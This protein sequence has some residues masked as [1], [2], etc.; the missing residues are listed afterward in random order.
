MKKMIVALLFTFWLPALQVGAEEVSAKP[1]ASRESKLMKLL[2]GWNVELGGGRAFHPGTAETGQMEGWSNSS[3]FT[4]R[5]GYTPKLTKGY[6]EVQ[7]EYADFMGYDSATR[8]HN[9]WGFTDKNRSLGIT[10]WSLNLKLKA[11][12]KVKQVMLTPYIVT[13]V[14]RAHVTMSS[15]AKAIGNAGNVIQEEEAT[16]SGSGNCVKI[17]GGMD[18]NLYKNVYLWSEFTLSKI[19]V[20]AME[21]AGDTFNMSPYTSTAVGGLGLRF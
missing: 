12:L 14:G 9:T 2:D 15:H 7:G 11:P 20:V 5:V 16:A 1:L 3:V 21:G 17:G 4:A 19:G 10:T 8:D 13:G 6:L 18:V